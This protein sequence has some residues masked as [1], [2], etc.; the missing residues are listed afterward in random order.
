MNRL[1]NLHLAD[2]ALDNKPQRQL[3]H[4]GDIAKQDHQK[5]TEEINETVANFE[6]DAK[7]AA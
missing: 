4:L 2:I 7:D 6:R 1:V 3:T 5:L